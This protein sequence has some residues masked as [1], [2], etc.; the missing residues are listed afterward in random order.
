CADLGVRSIVRPTRKLL[1]VLPNL[2]ECSSRSVTESGS[3]LD[4]G[5]Q[6]ALK[7]GWR[8]SDHPQHLGG[9]SLLLQRLRQ[10]PVALLQL[11]EEPRVLDRN[12]GLIRKR[13]QKSN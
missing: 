5:V 6:D 13:L 9:G 8:R 3:A 4:D 11:L 2:V 10:F 12:H 7:V 1:I